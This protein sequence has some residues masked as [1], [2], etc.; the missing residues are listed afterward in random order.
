[1]NGKGIGGAQMMGSHE[2]A[3]VEGLSHGFIVGRIIDPLGTT[4]VC[5]CVCVSERERER[6]SNT[7]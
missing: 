5:V 3:M 7:Y 4:C 2:P 1:M 6:E